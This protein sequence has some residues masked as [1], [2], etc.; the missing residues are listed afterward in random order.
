MADAIGVSQA[1]VSALISGQT[2][3][4]GVSIV[5]GLSSVFGVGLGYVLGLTDDQTLG[6]P[7]P[8]VSEM[9]SR[10]L[11]DHVTALQRRFDELAAHVGFASEEA[12]AEKARGKAERRGKKRTA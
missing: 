3:D 9:E 12:K 11:E 8:S 6:A 4:P 10:S 2:K 5:L 7:L 1:T